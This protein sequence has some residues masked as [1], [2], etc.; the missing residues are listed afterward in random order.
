M[1]Y[2]NIVHTHGPAGNSAVMLSVP[3]LLCIFQKRLEQE[4]QILKHP[5]MPAKVGHDGAG[6]Q[7]EHFHASL[8]SPAHTRDTPTHSEN[9]DER[10][11]R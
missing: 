9:Y 8:L 1:R 2:D 11:C 7:R 3:Y 5:K 10:N 4:S 6:M